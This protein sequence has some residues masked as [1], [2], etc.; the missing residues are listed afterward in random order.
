MLIIQ[1]IINKD[2]LI[3][4]YFFLLICSFATYDPFETF[5]SLTE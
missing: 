5:R 4:H 3:F 1:I 2:F